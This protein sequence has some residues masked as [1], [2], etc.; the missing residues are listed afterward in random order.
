MWEKNIINRH[1]RK[2]TLVVRERGPSVIWRLL[3]GQIVPISL[4]TIKVLA[5]V[6]WAE[7]E[8]A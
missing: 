3:D 2:E 6:D 5:L 4:G 7:L 1:G 8:E